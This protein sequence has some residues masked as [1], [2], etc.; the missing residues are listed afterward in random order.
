VLC[1]DDYG[2][3]P[4]VSR[5]ILTLI[6]TG[7]LSA[8]SCMTLC[9]GWPDQA[10][11]LRPL[12]PRADIGL[13]F[14]LTGPA[15]APLGPMPRL[16][17][18]GRLPTLGTVMARSLSGRLDAH[19]VAAEL[20][21]QIDAFEAAFGA[22]PAYID[23]HQHVHLLPGI[24]EAVITAA[25]GRLEPVRPWIRLC[26]DPLPAVVGRAVATPKALLIGGLGR[27]LRRLARR[28]G[29][30]GNDSFRGIYDLTDR[31]PFAGLMA[32]F[33]AAPRGKTLVMC[34]PGHVD[35]ELRAVDPVTDQ[36]QREFDF[37]SGPAFPAL[38]DRLGLCPARFAE[39]C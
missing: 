5:A 30:P 1:A 15:L 21:R 6:E 24:R 37:L 33:L 3:S 20:G 12:A 31:K 29:I 39:A 17:P 2:L 18:D 7:R 36:R 32:R 13:H 27:P 10:G 11:W 14:T 19:E 9:R 35:T 28:A 25:L 23:G 22:P 16:A 26:D 38:L 8:T 34:H 4:G